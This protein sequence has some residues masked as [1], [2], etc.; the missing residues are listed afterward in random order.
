MLPIVLAYVQEA[1]TSQN[2]LNEIR[3]IMCSL[4][5]AKEISKQV[6]EN[7]MNLIKL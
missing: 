2:L 5:S 3:Q 4:Y 6:C 7:I 1:T